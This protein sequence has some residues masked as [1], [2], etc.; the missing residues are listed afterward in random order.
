MIIRNH[1]SQPNS[2]WFTSFMKVITNPQQREERTLSHKPLAKLKT[3]I[4]RNK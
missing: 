3:V 2:V 4:F 1:Y